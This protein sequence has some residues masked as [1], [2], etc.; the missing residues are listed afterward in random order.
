MGFLMRAK[1]LVE[2]HA[3]QISLHDKVHNSAC[4][5]LPHSELHIQHLLTGQN[6]Q[7]PWASASSLYCNC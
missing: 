6:T 3:I 7:Q 4:K 1:P 5:N 2:L